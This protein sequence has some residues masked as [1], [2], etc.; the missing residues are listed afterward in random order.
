M[1]DVFIYFFY[2]EGPNLGNFHL[3][4]KNFKKVRILIENSCRA[5]IEVLTHSCHPQGPN[6]GNLDLEKFFFKKVA[7]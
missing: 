7:N 1:N 4:N 2:P 6:L 3:K 5:T